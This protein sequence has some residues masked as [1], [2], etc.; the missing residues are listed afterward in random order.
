M[1]ILPPDDRRYLI[2]KSIDFDE[3]DE[4]ARKAIV[5]LAHALPVGRFDVSFADIL[6]LLPTGYPD[7]PPDMFYTVPWIKLS[8]DGRYP[9][10]ADQS[11]NFAGKNWRRWSRHNKEWRAGVDGIWTMLK[12]I[13]NALAVAA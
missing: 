3:I 11:I 2:N 9:K 8:P 4:G 6:I 5:L 7:I 12:R 13:D 10:R 1:P